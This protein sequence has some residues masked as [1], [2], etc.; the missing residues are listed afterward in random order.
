MWKIYNNRASYCL[1]HRIDPISREKFYASIV[2]KDKSLLVK[3]I[4]FFNCSYSISAN[5]I[6][7]LIEQSLGNKATLI[8]SDLIH[9][10]RVI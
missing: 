1:F 8:Y 4:D 3:M 2:K 10:L 5:A 9:K 6:M 7:D